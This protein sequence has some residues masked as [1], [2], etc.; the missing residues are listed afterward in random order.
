MALWRMQP[1]SRDGG[2]PW[3][4]PSPFPWGHAAT[5]GLIWDRTGDEKRFAV[6][7]AWRGGVYLL[8][9]QKKKKKIFKT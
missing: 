5:S 4:P 8:R 9:E 3:G 7:S 6:F 1:G 2:D